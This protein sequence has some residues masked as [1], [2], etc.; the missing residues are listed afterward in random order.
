MGWESTATKVATVGEVMIPGKWE[1]QRQG[2]RS[3]TF[4]THPSL[5]HLLISSSTGQ[6]TE[7]LGRSG[8]SQ[9]K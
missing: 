3:L 5:R 1:P 4:F 8:S 2:D 6:A 9:D 7:K